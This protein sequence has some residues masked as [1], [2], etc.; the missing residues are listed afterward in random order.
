MKLKTI[1]SNK[2]QIKNKMIN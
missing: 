2:T 1:I